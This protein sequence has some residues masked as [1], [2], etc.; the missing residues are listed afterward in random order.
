MFKL[1]RF[2]KPY[3][4][5]LIL[6]PAAK[7]V[8]AV[9]ELVLPL[10]MADLIDTGIKTG[11]SEYIITKCIQMAVVSAI[12]LLCAL[13]CQYSASIASQGFGTSLRSALMEKINTFSFAEMERYGTTTL[14]NRSTNDVN[15]LQLAVAML[16]RL[17][18]RAPFLCIGGIIMAIRI[19]W[20]L[21]VILLIFIP[22]FILILYLI[23]K[24]T[25]PLYKSVQKKLDALSLVLRE[26][27]TGV[28]VIRAFNRSVDER[29]RFRKANRDWMDTAIQAGKISALMSPL[30]LLI[31][32]MAALL[33]IWIGGFRVDGGNLTQG[34]LIAF[35]NYITQIM[36]ALIVVANLAVLFN[37]A[38]A[39]AQRVNEILETQPSIITGQ[40]AVTVLPE[41]NGKKAVIEF[42][43]VSFAYTGEGQPALK[44]ISFSA[45]SGSTIG[46]IGGTGAGKSTL[47]NLIPRFYD[48]SEGTVYVEGIDVKK[49]D[50]NVLHDAIGMVPQKASLFSGT[51]R[52]NILWGKR[53]AQQ[54]EIEQAAEISQAAEFIERMPLKYNTEISQGGK[55]LSGGQRQ[56][57]TIA[58]AVIKKPVILILDDSSSALDYM[59]DFKLRTALRKLET[60]VTLIVSQRVNAVKDADRI[61][62]LD[63]GRLAGSGSHEQL[64]KEN[65]VYREICLSQN[66]TV[67]KKI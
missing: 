5:Q 39:S 66:I 7:L 34:Q 6:G 67:D 47:I 27:L 58:R 59:T 20:K 16:I 4:I 19:D 52:E 26:N 44:D 45:E 51:I 43:N 24:K 62:V 54:S 50:Q 60:G 65:Q 14:V 1:A 22:V 57:L 42:K 36:L 8:E 9:F 21:A 25:I 48:V 30:T 17:V 28:R 63:D 53:D 32:N 31:M 11:N 29:E 35:I 13:F 41:D 18:I 55:N 2:L 33:I 3:K 49:Y 15:Q 37:R 38:F 23:M 40:N 56:R 10:L 46:I 61:L 12:G 64:F